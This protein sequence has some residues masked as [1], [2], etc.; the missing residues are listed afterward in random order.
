MYSKI[1]D[2]K[3][4]ALLLQIIGKPELNQ[5]NNPEIKKSFRSHMKTN[6]LKKITRAYLSFVKE[7]I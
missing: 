7:K 3:K 2:D 5:Y 4:T 6:F 1:H